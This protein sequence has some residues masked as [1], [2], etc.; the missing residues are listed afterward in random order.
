MLVEGLYWLGLVDLGYAFPA[1]QN[2]GTAPAGLSAV[3]LTA[4]GR[5]LLLGEK[6]PEIPAETGHVVVQPNF[7]I[8]A[9]DPIADSVL[10]HLDSFAGRL[11]AER[12]IE[13][14]ITHEWIYRAQSA[15]MTVPELQAWLEEVTGAPLPQNVARSLE[16]WQ[17]AFERILV[18]PQ[19]ALLQAAAPEL[20][21]SLCADPVLNRA[22]IKQVSPTAVLVRPE[23]VDLLERALL[24]AGSCP[25]AA[26]VRKKDGR[27]RSRWMP[28]AGSTL[29]IGRPACIPMLSCSHSPNSATAHGVL[30]PPAYAGPSG[31]VTRPRRFWPSWRP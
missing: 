24:S 7:H 18:R 16:E 5:W 1:T 3:R 28:K 20:I 4:M 9:F 26:A 17:A 23:Q 25:H 15:G 30:Q 14:E 2:G 29:P 13:Y 19:V 31:R 10:A 22:I 11:N 27:R 12:A 6:K 21:A 8:F